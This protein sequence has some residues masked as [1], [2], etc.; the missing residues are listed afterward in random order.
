[1]ISTRVPGAGYGDPSSDVFLAL[2]LII[3]SVVSTSC[4][5]ITGPFAFLQPTLSH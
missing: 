2:P 3:L 4:L 5:K 1:M